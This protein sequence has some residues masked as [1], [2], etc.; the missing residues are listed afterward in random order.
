MFIPLTILPIKRTQIQFHAAMQIRPSV[1]RLNIK[2]TKKQFKNAPCRFRAGCVIKMRVAFMAH[3]F[4]RTRKLHQFARTLSKVN[5][6]QNKTKPTGRNFHTRV[7]HIQEGIGERTGGA[8]T[9]TFRIDSKNKGTKNEKL[10]E[11]SESF[12]SKRGRCFITS[13]N[14]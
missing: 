6:K 12:L 3:N 2:N 14:K 5:K 9:H 4:G 7:E 1:G 10:N 13:L 8:Q 11:S